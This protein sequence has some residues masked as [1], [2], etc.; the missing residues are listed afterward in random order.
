MEDGIHQQ[1]YDFLREA[2]VQGICGPGR[3]VLDAR[4]ICGCCWGIYAAGGCLVE[5]GL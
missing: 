3:N 2:G 5:Q 4:R 1:D